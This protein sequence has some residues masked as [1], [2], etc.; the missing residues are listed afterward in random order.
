MITEVSID[1]YI[2]KNGDT[3]KERHQAAIDAGVNSVGI[4]IFAFLGF[5]SLKLCKNQNPLRLANPNLRA[6]ATKGGAYKKF[7]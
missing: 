1:L 5:R 3:V 6:T 2:A 4:L 7:Y